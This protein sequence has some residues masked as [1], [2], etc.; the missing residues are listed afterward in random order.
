MERIVIGAG[1]MLAA[2]CSGWQVRS[3]QCERDMA[4]LQTQMQE[5]VNTAQENALALSREL[6]EMTAIIDAEGVESE[7]DID[8]S[9][10]DYLLWLQQREDSTEPSGSETSNPGD[11]S[12]SKDSC[13]CRQYAESKRAYGVLQKD[14]LT[15]ARDCDIT[16]VRYNELL[17]LVLGAHDSLNK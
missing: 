2:F 9:Y 12:A 10:H 5:Q 17:K 8:T 1:L 3:W 7:D 11:T 4:Q 15:L 14:I 6:A 16:A 13:K